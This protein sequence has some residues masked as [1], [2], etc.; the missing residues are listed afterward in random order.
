RV[1]R[2]RKRR[3]HPQGPLGH[4]GAAGRR[5]GGTGPSH[6][7]GSGPDGAAADPD[8]GGEP[9]DPFVLGGRTFRSRLIVGTG[10]Y[11]SVEVM[12]AALANSGAEM[13]TMAI[14]YMNLEQGGA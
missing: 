14:R 2:R 11:S 6:G 5:P 8:P 1:C 7:G 13:V 10:K 12:Q 9:D 3:S 4:Y